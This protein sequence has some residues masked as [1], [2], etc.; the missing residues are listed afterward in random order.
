[1]TNQDLSSENI[2]SIADKIHKT[3]FEKSYSIPNNNNNNNNNDDDSFTIFTTLRYDPSTYNGPLNLIDAI[4]SIPLDASFFYLLQEHIDKIQRAGEYFEF[5]TKN[6][7]ISNLLNHLTNSLLLSNK[8]NSYRI[9]ISI[10]KSGLYSI[11]HSVLPKSHILTINVP[12][13][14]E[15]QKIPLNSI[16]SIP[17]YLQDWEGWNLY[18]DKVQSQPTP[19]TS[20]KTSIR[21]TYNNARLRFNIIPGDNREVLL[22]DNNNNVLEG[23]I[24]SV[25]FWRQL[26]DPFNKQLSF[27]WV[28]PNLASGCMDGVIR[29]HLLKS[30]LIVEGI[31][32]VKELQDGEYVLLMNGLMGVK[33]A[34]LIL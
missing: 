31:I 25:A 33:V 13:Y 29:K 15:F 9:K 28:T 5:P 16:S 17:A 19:F 3:Y 34:K 6:L 27:K 26:K 7:T 4:N 23:S 10:S 11:D 22:Q 20:F 12:Q 14:D 21:D 8:L 24:S 1:M 32:P 30:G 2:N 18:L